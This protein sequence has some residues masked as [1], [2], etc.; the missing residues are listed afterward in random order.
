MSSAKEQLFWEFEKTAIPRTFAISLEP[1]ITFAALARLHFEYG[2]PAELIGTQSK[3]WEFDLV[4]YPEPGAENESVAVEVKKTA[5]EV[6]KLVEHVTSLS[7]EGK[8][9]VTGTQAMRNS[10][11]KY[12]GLVERGAKVFWV[13]GPA[14]QNYIFKVEQLGEKRIALIPGDEGLLRHSS[15]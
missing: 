5:K 13:V 12:N 2:W 11:K 14:K 7:G 6:E 3:K 10:I 8:V 1:V 9:A 4:T 15:A